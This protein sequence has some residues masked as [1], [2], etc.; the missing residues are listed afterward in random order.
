MGGYKKIPENRIWQSAVV[1]SFSSLL[2]GISLTMAD[3][4]KTS[5]V[6]GANQLATTSKINLTIPQW[7]LVKSIFCIGALLGA[8]ISSYV[9]LKK[10]TCII[11]TNL[12]FV[13]GIA[14]FVA[15][16][17]YW[18]LIVTRLILGCGIG[19]TSVYV[20]IY[21]ESIAPVR[22]RGLMC[23]MH[24]LCTV[25]G[26]LVGRV[27]FICF[28]TP[29]NWNYAFFITLGLAIVQTAALFSI[30]DVV[31]AEKRDNSKSIF[32]LL[33]DRDAALSIVCVV[34][35]N[36]SQ[37][38]SGINGVLYY[39]DEIFRKDKHQKLYALLIG[40]AFVVSTVV[41]MFFVDNFGRKPL[42]LVSM[43]VDLVL[44]IVFPY[45]ESGMLFCGL[46]VFIVG[47]SFGLGPIISF[48]GGEVFPEEYKKPGSAVSLFCGW[49][50]TFLMLRYFE[51]IFTRFHSRCF[52]Y[53][54]IALA[55][56]LVYVV[57]FFKDTKGRPP[58]F[59]KLS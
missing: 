47:Y 49:L 19:F 39:T 59:Q 12:F 9:R 26:M 3:C 1:C 6:R 42:L 23:S 46:I 27:L 24:Q 38:A 16:E 20:P 50:L 41:S 22:S 10:K 40:L 34:L 17:S 7:D 57:F 30:F 32:A 14:L 51:V 35:L 33:T 37:Q 11:V 53:F 54:A 18:F 55:A 43:I 45:L 56:C 29:E 8:L 25:F 28:N 21:L 4:A 15:A 5:F 31:T 52:M 2:L 58:E 36:V 13:V 44:L 48:I